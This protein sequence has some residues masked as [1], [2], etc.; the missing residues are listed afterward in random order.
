MP[1]P[2]DHILLLRCFPIVSVFDSLSAN[3]LHLHARWSQLS[4]IY[5]VMY[6]YIIHS[7]SVVS[8]IWPFLTHLCVKHLS[9]IDSSVLV[10]CVI[11]HDLCEVWRQ[12]MCWQCV[13][14]VTQYNI[15]VDLLDTTW[16]HL[17]QKTILISNGY[18]MQAPLRPRLCMHVCCITILLYRLVVS[19][20]IVI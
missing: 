16:L 15:Y 20:C 14:Y 10:L 13:H 9:S 17:E 4:C 6:I 3:Y 8:Y 7:I 12:P 1:L 11:V 5:K 2:Y 19:M 18:I